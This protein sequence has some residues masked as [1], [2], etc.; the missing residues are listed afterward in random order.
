MRFQP[1]FELHLNHAAYPN[2]RCSELRIE[3]RAQHPTGARALARHRLLARQ[4]PHGL[5]VIAQLDDGA[6]VFRSAFPAVSE[7]VFGFELQVTGSEFATVTEL[8]AWTNLA[9]PVYRA[10]GPGQ[11]QLVPDS[12]E[13]RPRPGV[14]ALLEITGLTPALSGPS[15]FTL[16]FAARSVPWVYYLLTAR[17]LPEPPRIEDTGSKPLTFVREQ[18]TL[19]KT[20]ASADPIGRRLLERHPEHRCYRFRSKKALPL[21]RGARRKLAVHLGEQLLIGE[22]PP[23]SITNFTLLTLK[24]GP[25][26]V[27]FK[28]VEY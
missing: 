19:A 3:P 22:L 8:A 9:C 7:L 11:L 16:D 28:V 23:P 2:G 4:R 13:A 20:T 15:I 1:V 17:E 5:D 21:Q 27:L 6:D 24:T 14:A 25:R 18:L 12:L 10:T 26:Q